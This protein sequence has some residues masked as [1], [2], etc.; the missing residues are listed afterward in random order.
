VAL[1]RSHPV[2][3]TGGLRWLHVD[4]ETVVFVREAADESVLVLATRGGADVELP[5]GAVAVAGAETLFGDATLAAASD[6]S[7]VLAVEGPAFAAWSLP[8]VKLP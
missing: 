6:G 2:L 7:V 4:D 8:G 5:V 1:R 3:A